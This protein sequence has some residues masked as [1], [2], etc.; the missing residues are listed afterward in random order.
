MAFECGNVVPVRSSQAH[1]SSR[2]IGTGTSMR[3]SGVQR[4]E[5]KVAVAGSGCLSRRSS[6]PQLMVSTI[7]CLLYTSPSPRD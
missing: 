6:A 2:I 3:V 7:C 1:A 4:T 5:A